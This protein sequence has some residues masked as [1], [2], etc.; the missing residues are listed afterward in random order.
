MSGAGRSPHSPPDQTEHH[1]AAGHRLVP[2]T[3]GLG[4]R[5]MGSRSRLVSH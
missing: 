5:G 1:S 4:D 3:R 2:H